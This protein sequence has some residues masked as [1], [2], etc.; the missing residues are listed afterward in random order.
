MGERCIAGDHVAVK[1]VVGEI[2][3]AAD[4]EVGREAEAGEEAEIPRILPTPLLPSKSV[5]DAHRET[6]C[7]YRSWCEDCR[8]GCG[9]EMPHVVS[10]QEARKIPIVGFDVYTL[11]KKVLSTETVLIT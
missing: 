10:D 3:P 11:K 7:P 9:L 5:M 1:K 2:H 4:E 8:A 6:H